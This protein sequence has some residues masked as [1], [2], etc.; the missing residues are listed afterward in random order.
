[1]DIPL[2][3][4][5]GFLKQIDASQINDREQQALRDALPHFWPSE[6]PLSADEV[7][8]LVK[9][10]FPSMTE[11]IESRMRITEQRGPNRRFSGGAGLPRQRYYTLSR[12]AA[13]NDNLVLMAEL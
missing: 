13:G 2:G 3:T 4:F 7:K 10:T 12:N 8:A 5:S 9:R 11:A 1:M 6:S